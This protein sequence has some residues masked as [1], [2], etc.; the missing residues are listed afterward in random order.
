MEAIVEFFTVKLPA[1]LAANP[2]IAE[3]VNAIYQFNLGGAGTWTVDLKNGGKITEGAAEKADCQV[4]ASADDFAKL[5][6]NPAG[7]VTM[8]MSGKLKVNPLG[9]GMA[10]QK[11]I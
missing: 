6:A 2:Q 7:A 8:F 10:L 11:L 9:L 1:K 5:L 3:Q 4:D